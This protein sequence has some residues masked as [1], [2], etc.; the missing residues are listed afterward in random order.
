MKTLNYCLEC[1]RV[2]KSN[3]RCEFCSSNKIKPLKKGT[4]VNVIGSKIKGSIFSYKEDLVSL[5]IIT[6]GK[7]RIVKEYKSNAL[8]KIL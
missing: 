4:S 2:F 5:I 6:E 7:E 8:K 1:R 3:E